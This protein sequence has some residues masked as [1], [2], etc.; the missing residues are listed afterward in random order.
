MADQQSLEA[1]EKMEQHFQRLLDLLNQA[2]QAVREVRESNSSFEAAHHL[3]AHKGQ[4]L[5]EAITNI[6]TVLAQV[7][8]IHNEAVA[9]V[10]A[11]REEVE[12]REDETEG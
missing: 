11:A 8:G 5:E 3:N 12:Q 10:H 4:S 2:D 7:N 1:L 6:E 9:H